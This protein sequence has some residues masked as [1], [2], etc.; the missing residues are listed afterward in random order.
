[1][2]KTV[3][4]SIKADDEDFA[5]AVNDEWQSLVSAI[6]ALKFIDTDKSERVEIA[7]RLLWSL[8]NDEDKRQALGWASWEDLFSPHQEELKTLFELL[9]DRI[10][11]NSVANQQRF[12]NM[13]LI[14]S[15]PTFREMHL[16]RERHWTPI[17]QFGS[18]ISKL[19]ALMQ[20]EDGEQ[21]LELARKV[22]ERTPNET[23][24]PEPGDKDWEFNGSL[25]KWRGKK[26]L[27][28][29]GTSDTAEAK[30]RN[31]LTLYRANFVLKRQDSQI[32]AATEKDTH[33]VAN[34]L[35]P[36]S[37]PDYNDFVAW[38]HARFGMKVAG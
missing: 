8:W 37:D 32:L 1:M 13:L 12:Y 16:L 29:N 25:G 2:I 10:T 38:L 34:V 14:D 23:R 24:D 7:C 3:P 15:D 20:E 9:E 17:T 28:M 5:S 27:R 21:K 11:L 30:L 19:K 4:D 35:L 22:V 6:E 18:R 26:A 31:R 36:Q 33:A